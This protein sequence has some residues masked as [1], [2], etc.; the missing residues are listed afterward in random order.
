MAH[1]HFIMNNSS[2]NGS[3]SNENCEYIS[4]YRQTT[5]QN[6]I[7]NCFKEM[8]PT[9]QLAL[10]PHHSHLAVTITGYVKCSLRHSLA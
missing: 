10:S 9:S 4:S 1:Y 6:N 5:Q 2:E 7:C 3:A 8:T